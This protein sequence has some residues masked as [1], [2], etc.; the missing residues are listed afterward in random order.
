MMGLLGW[1]FEADVTLPW[2][3][4]AKGATQPD[5]SQ[6]QQP[7]HGVLEGLTERPLW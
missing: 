3:H 5:L 7:S 4:H 2:P 1:N 6:R